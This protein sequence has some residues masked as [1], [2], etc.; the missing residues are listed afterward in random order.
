MVRLFQESLEEVK[1]DIMRRKGLTRAQ[2]FSLDR[3]TSAEKRR[4]IEL[5]ISRE[6]ILGPLLHKLLRK[7][8]G[9]DRYNEEATVMS[10]TVRGSRG[11]TSAEHTVKIPSPMDDPQ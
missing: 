8:K 3:F 10:T 9:L 4:V 6:D 2:L 11:P 7:F 5:L 1:A